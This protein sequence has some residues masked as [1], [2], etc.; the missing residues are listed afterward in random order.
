MEHSI[1]NII[2]NLIDSGP[3]SA[4]EVSDSLGFSSKT[5]R[6]RYLAGDWTLPEIV[7]LEE[8]FGQPI[9]SKFTEYRKGILGHKWQETAPTETKPKKG[10]KIMITIDP[11]EFDANDLHA[12]N[13]EL[14]GL[15]KR[16]FRKKRQ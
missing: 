16:G 1:H 10:Y 3:F 13:A 8:L 12:L 15:L 9:I 6:R 4:Q 11:E 2:I 5:L 14:T 7:K